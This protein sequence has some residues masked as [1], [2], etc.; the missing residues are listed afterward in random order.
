[1]PGTILHIY[2]Q[3]EW[4]GPAP[5]PVDPGAFPIHITEYPTPEPAT[6]LLLSLG[7]LALVR[8]R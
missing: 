5:Y 6:L 7:A 1:L 3:L 8:R 4:R 2:K